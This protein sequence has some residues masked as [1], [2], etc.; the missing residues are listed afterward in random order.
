M[1]VTVRDR[2]ASE[3]LLTALAGTLPPG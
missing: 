1:R 2:P 3:R